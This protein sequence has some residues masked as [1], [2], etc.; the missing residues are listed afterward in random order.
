MQIETNN[1]IANQ[2]KLTILTPLPKANTALTL[3]VLHYPNTLFIIHGSHILLV[4]F[5]TKLY[6]CKG[7]N[8]CSV[9]ISPP[10]EQGGFGVNQELGFWILEMLTQIWNI[11]RCTP[12]CGTQAIN[13]GHFKQLLTWWLRANKPLIALNFNTFNIQ[14]PKP[15][16][17]LA[18]QDVTEILRRF[19][20]AVSL[21][22]LGHVC[23]LTSHSSGMPATGPPGDAELGLFH[24]RSAGS[25]H[26][27]HTS[28]RGNLLL[29]AA[30]RQPGSPSKCIHRIRLSKY[31]LRSDQQ[32]FF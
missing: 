3:P 28:T 25:S 19:G 26:P 8:L 23:H 22:A 4:G 5:S 10:D 15:F 29:E 14:I 21:P 11:S 32:L 17:F 9:P 6:P 13:T 30:W 24:K 31:W 27:Q 7:S 1:I 16:F 18:A 20:T 12:S 2:T